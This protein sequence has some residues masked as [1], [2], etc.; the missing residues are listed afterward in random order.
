MKDREIIA[1]LW[2]LLDNIDTLDDA[3]KADDGAF[4]NAV[5]KHQRRRFETGMT[6]DGYSL[7]MPDGELLEDAEGNLMRFNL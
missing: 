3:I 7:W 5:R 1:F 2:R 4:R 6:T